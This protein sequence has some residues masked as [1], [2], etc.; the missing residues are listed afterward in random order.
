[1]QRNPSRKGSLRGGEKK[2]S[3]TTATTTATA[4]DRDTNV[5]TSSPRGTYYY[6]LYQYEITDSPTFV[7][8]TVLAIIG[9]FLS[10]VSYYQNKIRQLTNNSNT[11]TP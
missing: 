1:L 9:L 11:N 10:F 4:N 2:I 6:F 7:V 8:T 3:P 5:A